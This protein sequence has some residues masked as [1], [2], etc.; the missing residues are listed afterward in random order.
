MKQ[1]LY[2]TLLTL[3]LSSCAKSFAD[4][5]IEQHD[6]VVPAMAVFTVA[7]QETD[8]IMWSIDGNVYTDQKQA[9]Q[10]IKSGKHEVTVTVS[11]GGKSKSKTKEIF[12]EAPKDCL[13]QLSTP[14]GK[15]I[16]KLYD[17]TPI[18]RDNFVKLV[19]EAFYNGTMFHRVIDGFMIQGGDPKSKGA[20]AND[21]LGSGGPGYQ[22]DA[23]IDERF[24]HTKG[25]LAAARL[26]GPGNP[27]KKSSGSQFYIVQ[28]KEV[29]AEALER[30]EN[31]K[32]ITYTDSVKEDYLANGGT[33][34]LDGDYTV[35][36]KVIEG[37]DV[38]DKI[39]K[40]KTGSGDRPVEN[41][42]MNI[43][44]IK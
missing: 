8:Q 2:F 44:V 31:S 15:M 17:E 29:T 11:K 27:Q 13:M 32:G 22:L 7:E 26:G 12:F 42:I 36:G 28:G 4:F 30:I 9:H 10:F 14:H 39:A 6:M 19:E 37:L 3:V 5:T 16:F 25:S 24:A 1:L 40:L 34:F 41:V 18:H 21:M 20:S 35:F 33:P 23:E 38:I 43:T